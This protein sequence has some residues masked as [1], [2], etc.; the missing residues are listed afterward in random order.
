MQNQDFPAS[1]LKKGAKKLFRVILYFG[2]LCVTVLLLLEAC[3]RLYIFDFY[4][5]NFKGLNPN[6]L[7]YSKDSDP[8]VLALGDS[9]TAD[10]L[11]YVGH[12]RDSLL[13]TRVFNAAVPGT[14]IKQS[15][16]MARKRF[17]KVDP[18]VVIY[19]VYVGNDL[20]EYKHRTKGSSISTIR[21]VYWWL[22]DRLW[23]I[24]YINAKMPAIRQTVAN[25]SPV[26]FD[27]K[28]LADYDPAT[29]SRRVKLQFQTEPRLI[30][31]SVFLSGKR[32][33]DFE[34]YA[35]KV[36]DLTDKV[37]TGK[38]ILIV[39][40]PHCAQVSAQYQS[41]MEKI[42][43][44]FEEQLNHQQIIYPF[45][46]RLSAKLERPGLSMINTLPV[47]QKAERISPVFYGNDPH[48]NSFGQTIIGNEVID[49]LRELGYN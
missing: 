11:G 44:K 48:L 2:F 1:F 14:T 49:R 35:K 47:L 21:K 22:S 40:I 33:K 46:E 29:Y 25:T 27:P 18:G 4:G 16:L 10:P 26:E 24:G 19:Q 23:V 42:G 17:R 30:S 37:D 12:L 38:N 41:N 3:Y 8:K 45:L 32:E 6:E 15:G 13:N 43:A 31:N 9:F 36:K 20:F 28:T 34:A 7:T 39:V 5:G